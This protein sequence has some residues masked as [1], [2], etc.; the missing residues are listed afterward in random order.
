MFVDYYTVGFLPAV[1]LNKY[2]SYETTDVNQILPT[3]IT[4]YSVFQFCFHPFVHLCCGDLVR[5][6]AS[7]NDKSAVSCRYMH[8]LRR[9]VG[10]KL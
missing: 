7:V 2:F 5:T 9:A 10:Q 6:K 1:I 3:E 4:V 8:H